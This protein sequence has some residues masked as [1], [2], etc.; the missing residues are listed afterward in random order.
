MNVTQQAALRFWAPVSAL[1]VITAIDPFVGLGTVRFAHLSAFQDD[2]FYYLTIARN[3]AEHGRS[4][5]DGV[6]LTNGY[7][8]LWALILTALARMARAE[9]VTFVVLLAT[10][11]CGL[12]LLSA[13]LMQRL[14]RSLWPDASVSV[15]LGAFVFVFAYAQLARTGMEAI[16]AIPAMLAAVVTVLDCREALSVRRALLAA[17]CCSAAILARVDLVIFVAILLTAAAVSSTGRARDRTGP[18]L[19]DP[20]VLTAIAIGLAPVVAYA[21]VNEIVFGRLM[22]QSGAAKQIRSAVAFNPRVWQFLVLPRRNARD[23]VYFFL[24]GTMPC[25][26]ALAGLGS[27]ALRPAATRVR[28]A[29]LSLGGF[30]V[31]YYAVLS[32]ISDWALWIWYFYPAVAAGGL[33]TT[34]LARGI[35]QR[36]PRKAPM[37]VAAVL[38]AIAAA[39]VLSRK[40]ASNRILAL[41]V[42]IQDFATT[43]PGTY[44]MGD[45]AGAAGFLLPHGLVQL[46]GLVSPPPLLTMVRDEAPLDVVFQRFGVD[47]YVTTGRRDEQGCVSSEE[48]SAQLA[49]PRSRRMRGRFCSAPL[50]TFDVG[51]NPTYILD[52]HQRP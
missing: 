35:E 3:L 49:G 52:V 45:M 5:F 40:P 29:M 27:L 23:F 1:A 6:S 39:G 33:A 42:Q 26:L 43:H 18:M 34:F 44:A 37:A 20:K 48:P 22:P 25:L 31:V 17:L 7:H 38:V 41:G 4:T 46:E 12:T 50:A 15:E 9:S 11:V 16:V 36:V 28:I 14:A 8:P 10:L 13:W 21:V 32:F 51:R 47:Y 24:V 30:M 2:F 19:R